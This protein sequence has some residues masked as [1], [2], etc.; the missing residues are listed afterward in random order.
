[1]STFLGGKSRGAFGQPIFFF[2][3]NG[4]TI[5]TLKKTEVS[6]KA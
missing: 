3:G 5:V 1:M 4:V 2:A 6:L